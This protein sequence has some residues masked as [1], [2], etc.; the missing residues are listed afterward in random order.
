MNQEIPLDESTVDGISRRRVLKRIG[1]GVA[2]AWT[3]PVLTSLRT[4]AFAQSPTCGCPPYDCTNPAFCD[5]APCECSPPHEGGPCICTLAGLCSGIGQNLCA[6][7]QDCVAQFGPG[8]RCGDINAG[9]C[10]QCGGDTTACWDT[11]GCTSNKAQG[12]RTGL[13]VRG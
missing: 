12:P 6:N 8:W 10:P 5:N 7:D 4:P 11:A 13:K 2:I 1:G 3:A 9:S